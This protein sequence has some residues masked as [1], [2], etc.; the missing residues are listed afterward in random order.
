MDCDWIHSWVWRW[1]GCIRRCSVRAA[2]ILR[3][4]REGVLQ[5]SE[6]LHA[7][8]PPFS[9]KREVRAGSIFCQQ[10]VLARS[11]D[12]PLTLAG[13]PAVQG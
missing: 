3:D 10:I 2:A 6:A 1:T 11:T 4:G 8:R 9:H 12:A 13:P 7:F 5:E